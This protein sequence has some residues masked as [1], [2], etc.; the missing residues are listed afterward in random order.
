LAG[1]FYVL[2]P[3]TFFYDRMALTEAGLSAITAFAVLLGIRLVE[4]GR[5]VHAVLCGLVLALAVF[6]K[7]IGGLVLPIPVLVALVLGRL[8]ERVKVLALAYAVGLPPTAW[9]LHRFVA[10]ENAQHMAQ[11]FTGGGGALAARFGAALA[12][13]ASWL[14]TWWTPP[15]AL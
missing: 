15:L 1:V 3:F 10:T 4:S 13:G 5:P 7:A 14:W 6:V 9:A 8:R 2:C 12:E 11:L